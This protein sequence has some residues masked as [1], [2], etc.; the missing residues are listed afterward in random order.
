MNYCYIARCWFLLTMDGVHTTTPPSST[1]HHHHLSSLG[2]IAANAAYALTAEDVLSQFREHGYAK[3]PSK[4]YNKNTCLYLKTF[5]GHELANDTQAFI[6]R[7][8]NVTILA[9][10]GTEQRSYSDWMNDARCRMIPLAQMI[11][12]VFSTTTTTTADGRGGS[13]IINKSRSAPE[14]KSIFPVPLPTS[15]SSSSSR[16]P[17]FKRL[18]GCELSDL[19]DDASV[20]SGFAHA[21]F[22]SNV[23]N[24][25]YSSLL[26][27]LNKPRDHSDPT[28][29]TLLVCGHSLG[30]ALAILFSAYLL[31]DPMHAAEASLTH[32][33]VR[34]FGQPKVGNLG[35]MAMMRALLESTTLETS[36]E[37]FVF[38]S[39]LVPRLPIGIL[40]SYCFGPGKYTLLPA[41][42]DDPMIRNIE[43]DAL[44][45]RL[46]WLPSVTD[47]SMSNYV[48]RLIE[49]PATPTDSPDES[50]DHSSSDSEAESD[51]A[52]E[53][54]HQNLLS[55]SS[56]RV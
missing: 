47:H 5:L 2:A 30:G 24:Q 52:H 7:F 50:S 14:L 6:L 12:R 43:P 44:R 3:A 38:G 1:H 13:N 27:A 11:S 34:T 36:V 4:K 9:F 32:L 19:A 37:Q 21:L 48:A 28:P 35:A 46:T 17:P 49:L 51:G 20:H 31:L 26:Y 25:L 45:A 33:A 10:R 53:I 39:D 8:G 29:A 56:H 22:G 15:A 18:S 55:S 42:K 41:N 54:P 16:P 40:F 23:A